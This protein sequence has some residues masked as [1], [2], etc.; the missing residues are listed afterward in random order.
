MYHNVTVVA[1][2]HN[3]N[4]QDGS[5]GQRRNSHIAV[6][7]RS[8]I[9]NSGVGKYDSDIALLFMERPFQFT[10]TVQPICLPKDDE[11]VPIGENCIITGWGTNNISRF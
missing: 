6:P 5:E 2:I 11:V 1:G 10:K 3:I 4:S 9:D 8:Y 7:N